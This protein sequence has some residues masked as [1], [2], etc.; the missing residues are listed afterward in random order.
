MPD[1]ITEL[2][3]PETEPEPMSSMSFLEH[4]EEL[5]T[6]IFHAL[7]AIAIGMGF[8]L[9][10]GALNQAALARDRARAAAVCWIAVAGA[11]VAWM[12]TDAIAGV[13]LRAEV[14]YAGA[15]GVAVGLVLLLISR[16]VTRLM[17]GVK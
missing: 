7:I 15:T 16:P 3:S 14:G 12:L 17:G 2:E 8:H 9:S 11:F 4:L 1:A 6:R 13:V 5:R 10:A